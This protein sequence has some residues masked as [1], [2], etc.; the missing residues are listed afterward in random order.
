ML[1]FWIVVGVLAAPFAGK[2]GDEKRDNTVDHLPDSA[3]STQAARIQQRLPGGEPPRS[4][5]TSER[6]NSP[7][8]TGPLPSGRPRRS[9]TRTGCCP[10]CRRRLEGRQDPDGAP[11][12]GT[13]NEETARDASVDDVRAKVSGGDGL[14]V[15]VGGPGSLQTDMEEVFETVDGTLMIATV[16]VV[17]VLLIITDRSPFRWTTIRPAARYDPLLE[18]HGGKRLTL[19]MAAVPAGTP[20]DAP[21]ARS[22]HRRLHPMA[23]R[24]GRC[25]LSHRG[26][27]S[28]PGAATE[29]GIPGGDPRRAMISVQL[30]GHLH[31]EGPMART[32]DS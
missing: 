10:P 7:P 5:S 8:P 11:R 31:G 26:I 2:L 4:S 23:A 16:L 17:T 19:V 1:L 29:H 27:E 12:R 30:S 14:S 6:A 13:G 32:L 9:P 15:E 18:P 25:L 22:D 3:D 24:R 20:A 28:S 21:G